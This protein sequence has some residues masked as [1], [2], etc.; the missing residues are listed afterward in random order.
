MG[1]SCEMVDDAWRISVPFAQR[2]GTLEAGGASWARREACSMMG[3]RSYLVGPTGV[4]YNCKEHGLQR[5]GISSVTEKR[6]GPEY[7]TI[8]MYCRICNNLNSIAYAVVRR[9]AGRKRAEKWY[10]KNRERVLARLRA[11]RAAVKWASVST[12]QKKLASDVQSNH[13]RRKSRTKSW[14][15]IPIEG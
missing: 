9:T 3:P 11:R 6:F 2:P 15:G 13:A 8:K 14:V 1:N 5:A 7:H 12:V 10:A 4:F